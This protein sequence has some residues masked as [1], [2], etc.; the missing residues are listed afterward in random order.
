LD[1]NNVPL[2][3]PVAL[4]KSLSHNFREADAIISLSFAGTANADMLIELM[5]KTTIRFISKESTNERNLFLFLANA[6]LADWKDAIINLESS[7][8]KSIQRLQ[9]SLITLIKMTGYY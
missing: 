6:T 1:E 3:K 8:N 5:N 9:Q 2:D 7:K 4:Q